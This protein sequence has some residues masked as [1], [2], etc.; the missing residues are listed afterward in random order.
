MSLIGIWGHSCVGK[1]TWLKSI[2]DDLPD[3][4]PNLT[5]ILA[6][7]EQEYHYD[8]VT[9]SWRYI[10]NRIRWKGT[11]EQ[12]RQWP[13]G[14][15]ILSDRVYI[16]ESMR[17]FNGMRADMLAAWRARGNSG[18][19][20]ILPYTTIE[21]YR[22]MQ[23]QR[24]I[25]LNKPMSPWWELDE[26]L[27]KEINYRRGFGKHWCEPNH[28]PYKLIEIDVERKNWSMATEYLKEVLSTYAKSIPCNGRIG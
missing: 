14:D 6:D 8:P 4:Y 26:H 28:V 9:D 1:T 20:M 17:Y 25:S 19:H 12:K 13:I 22:E 10:V 21:I 16:L 23:R 27:K 15:L 3:I 18:I 2:M 24:C 7:N 5:V 11:K